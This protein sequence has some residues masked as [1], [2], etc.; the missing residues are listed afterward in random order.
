MLAVIIHRNTKTDSFIGS[1]IKLAKLGSKYTLSCIPWSLISPSSRLRTRPDRP[2]HH[3]SFHAGHN[4]EQLEAQILPQLGVKMQQ[5]STLGAVSRGECFSIPIYGI[6]STATQGQ[7]RGMGMPKIISASCL[8]LI[9]I[10]SGT[11]GRLLMVLFAFFTHT[12]CKC[13]NSCFRQQD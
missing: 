8:L 13:F 3:S 4:K 9:L 10:I 6:I 7:F 11:Q 5:W 2:S 1:C 12:K